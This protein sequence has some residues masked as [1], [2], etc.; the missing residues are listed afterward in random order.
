MFTIRC[1]SHHRAPCAARFPALAALVC[2]SQDTLVLV[3]VGYDIKDVQVSV[4]VVSQ[5]G[6]SP[7]VST[8]SGHQPLR[9]RSSGGA[10]LAWRLHSS[11][12]Q[13]SSEMILADDGAK[14]GRVRQANAL[15]VLSPW[16]ELFQPFFPSGPSW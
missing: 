11:C 15:Y 14:L 3:L 16:S 5:C 7:L 8:L 10:I 9:C 6:D 4:T 1:F 12:A 13:L 2:K